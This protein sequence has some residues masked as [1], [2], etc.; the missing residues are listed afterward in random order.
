MKSA[1]RLRWWLEVYLLILGIALLAVVIAIGVTPEFPDI[2]LA[3]M[4]AV[5]L[6]SF[7]LV[8]LVGGAGLSV[9]SVESDLVVFHLSRH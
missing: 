3:L 4:A 9:E 5:L 2:L 6:L 7:V 1:T 8:W